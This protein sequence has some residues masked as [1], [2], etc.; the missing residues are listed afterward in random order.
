MKVLQI[1]SGHY[2]R[3]GADVVYLNTTELLRA[4]GHDV[5]CFSLKDEK[6][7]PSDDE[8]Y[9]AENMD[10][11]QASTWQKIKAVPR[12]VH[13]RDAA[14]KLDRLLS[15]VKPDI[16]QIHIFL[17]KMTASILPVLKKHKV[18]VVF[19]MHDYR[20]ICPAYLFLDGKNQVCEKCKTGFYLNCT[21]QKCSEGNFF[22]SLLLTADAYYR[23]Y[24]INPL[25]YAGSFIF[26]S[27]FIRKKHI[28]F[29]AGYKQRARL[30]YNFIPE[31]EKVKP[32]HNKGSYFLFYGRLSRE[33]GVDTLI[34]AAI[35]A[36]IPL[37]LVGTGSLSEKYESHS[38]PNI[39]FLGHKSGDEL[40]NLVSHASFVV[41]PSEWYE[42]NPLTVLES[43][44][45]G[46]PVIGAAIGG[47]PEIVKHGR[48]GFLFDPGDVKD[49]TGILNEAI[50]LTE[51]EYLEFSRNARK[52]AETNF[53]PG[54]YYN[55]LIK[56]YQETIQQH[57]NDH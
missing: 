8:K 37:K 4:H 5:H 6:N 44:G 48:T 2:R 41:V 32:V 23:K 28:E 35:Q 15:E 3:G 56:I 43:Y 9:F 25:N 12:F 42:N 55:E 11:R 50:D 53:E 30:L 45:L 24:R 49:L 46:K 31:L 22:Q 26:V 39:E 29:N 19:T 20:F 13:N 47:I 38:Y 33:K 57:K 27:D 18:P 54:K 1:N 51:E 7:L 14:R 21:L 40:W 36:G 52:F 17:G 16:A 34:Q 10:L